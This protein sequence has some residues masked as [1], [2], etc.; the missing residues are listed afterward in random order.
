MPAGNY[1]PV[2]QEALRTWLNNFAALITAA[3]G[4]Y[5]LVAGDAVTI[6]DAADEFDAA[7]TL[8]LN[9]STRSPANIADKDA[10]RASA[11]GIVRPYAIMIR[12]NL[13][14]T[15]ENKIALGLTVIDRDPTP[16]PAPTTIPSVGVNFAT[17]LQMTLEYFD[18]ATPS[19]KAKPFGS[20]GIQ[21]AAKVSATPI[22]DPALLPIV[23]TTGK[24]PF[25]LDWAGADQGGRAYIVGR[26]ITRTGLTGPWGAIIESVVA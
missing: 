15:D 13:G 10:K 22:T 5:G 26:W 12:N 7:L 3:P 1:I 21:I 9:P 23:K 2:A 25:V 19:S 17:P 4:T 18:T 6:Q 8:A 16:I 14:V 11:N 20:I 24:S